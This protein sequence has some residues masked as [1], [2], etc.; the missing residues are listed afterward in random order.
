METP[1]KTTMI[2]QPNKNKMLQLSLI[3]VATLMTGCETQRPNVL[4]QQ[5]NYICKS[6]IDGF[7]KAQQLGQYQLSDIS[8]SLEQVSPQRHYIYSISSDRNFRLNMPKQNELKFICNQP[9]EQ[10]FS[11]EL[12][13][14][15]Q[16]RLSALMSIDLPPQQQIKKLTA[17]AL[18]QN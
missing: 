8:P 17:Y 13:D 2:L 18:N 6:L 9:T 3:G 12:F 10:R 16:Q 5:Q 15:S 4:A 7:L 1:M 11:V 14:P